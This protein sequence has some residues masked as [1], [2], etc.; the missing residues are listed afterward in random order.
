MVTLARPPVCTMRTTLSGCVGSSI[1][2]PTVTVQFAPSAPTLVS[3]GRSSLNCT[4]WP[5]RERVTAALRMMRPD[6]AATLLMSI[7]ACVS[8]TSQIVSARRNT[9]AG[10]GAAK[11]N[12]SR[13]ASP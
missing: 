12:V 9:A 10:V 5:S 3:F 8:N 13:T 1:M 7:G 2:S 11:G 4:T 6:C